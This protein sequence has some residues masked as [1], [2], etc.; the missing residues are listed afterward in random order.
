MV[1]V[2]INESLGANDLKLITPKLNG[3]RANP[4]FDTLSDLDLFDYCLYPAIP[5]LIEAGKNNVVAQ[6]KCW[7]LHPYMPDEDYEIEEVLPQDGAVG[8]NM[9]YDGCVAAWN[10]LS[11]KFK[12]KLISGLKRYK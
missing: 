6:G 3:R 4:V 5:E 1:L 11:D 2:H 8:D 10:N 12:K 9:T 7:F